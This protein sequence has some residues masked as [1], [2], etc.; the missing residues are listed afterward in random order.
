MKTNRVI[1]ILG[2]TASGKSAAAHAMFHNVIKN[3]GVRP[4]LVNLDAFQF[5]RGF[6]IGTAKP[7]I[8]EQAEYNYHGLD[9]L[10]PN[11]TIDASNYVSL[12][13][14]LIASDSVVICAGGSG[15]YTRAFLHGLDAM[16]PRAEDIRQFLRSIADHWGW[17]KV[18]DWLVQVDP[19]RAYALHPNDGVRIERALECFLLTG[20]PVSLTHTNTNTILSKQSV[21]HN[22]LVLQT[23]AVDLRPKI[24]LRVKQMLDIGWIDE[25][26]QLMNQQKIPTGEF[27][28]LPAM[29]AIGY[30]QIY[31]MLQGQIAMDQLHTIISQ[32]TWQY[33]KRQQTWNSKEVNHGSP[34]DWDLVSRYLD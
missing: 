20:S 1:V 31:Q 9:L 19:N 11:E 3:F 34:D 27:C 18:H 16:P 12:I 23:T 6:N 21:R 30:L 33:A 24:E 32:K 2:A 28:N 5:Y 29:R 4:K 14:K 17:A 7:N 10:D 25:V 15:L 22:A 26:R 8:E 13:D